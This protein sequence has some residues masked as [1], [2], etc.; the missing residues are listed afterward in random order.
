MF[1]ILITCT[2]ARNCWAKRVAG[3]CV[4]HSSFAFEQFIRWPSRRFRLQSD[5]KKLRRIIAVIFKSFSGGNGSHSHPARF[6]A[7][8]TT[9]KLLGFDRFFV[10]FLTG[11]GSLFAFFF[12][13]AEEMFWVSALRT[14]LKSG[15]GALFWRDF[16]EKLSVDHFI[17]GASAA[18]TE[19][20]SQVV[21][22]EEHSQCVQ[23]TSE[24]WSFHEVQF[25]QWR[26][27]WLSGFLDG[28]T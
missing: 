6:C 12:G 25:R 19:L 7:G 8:S 4:L 28:F 15:W 18:F 27:K 13:Y 16:K 24:A 20:M 3:I 9:S 11:K 5:R 23:Y 10:T 17:L 22:L 21:A 26:W 2:Y 1:Q 14:F